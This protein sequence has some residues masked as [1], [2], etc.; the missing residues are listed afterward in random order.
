MKDNI[1]HILQFFTFDP[2]VPAS[3]YRALSAIVYA[4][5]RLSEM[6][7][8][9]TEHECDLLR[10]A[11][12]ASLINTLGGDVDRFLPPNI[13]ATEA[14]IKIQEAGQQLLLDSHIDARVYLALRRLLEARDCVVRVM[15]P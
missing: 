4:A 6:T 13:E 7:H 10:H 12:A 3:A 8:E 1:R 14:V 15:I 5:K 9:E 2:F 11:Q